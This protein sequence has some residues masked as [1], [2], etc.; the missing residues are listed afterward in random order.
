MPL[1]KINLSLIEGKLTSLS[2]TPYF[3]QELK[4]HARQLQ[5]IAV[6]IT[7]QKIDY[8]GDWL[9]SAIR[10]LDGS[11]TKVLPY[12][13]VFCLEAAL[14]NWTNES[15]LI[16]TAV[17]HEKDFFFQGIDESFYTLAEVLCGE[18]FKHR[19]IQI[20][21]PDLYRHKPLYNS[22]LYH[23]LGH[24]IDVHKSIT[25]YLIL[26]NPKV[27]IPDL[28]VKPPAMSDLYYEKVRRAHLMEYFAD[29]FAACYIG[30]AIKNFLAAFAP[31]NLSSGSHPSTKNRVEN[32]EA[33][34]AG[35]KSPLIDAFSSALSALK[36]PSLAKKYKE[37]DLSPALDN[38]R[39][40]TLS[41]IEEVHGIFDSGWNYLHEALKKTRKPWS[42]LEENKIEKVI[43]DLIEKSI[44]NFMVRE[45]WK[46]GTS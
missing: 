33:L 11:T 1:T 34:L 13:V 21:L 10:Y 32:I 12:E 26:N 3:S 23:E 8:M 31:N 45:L 36:L 5:R 40:F 42:Q 30:P 28:D 19:L 16:T 14:K 24:F 29:L 9:W 25:E 46:H 35:K 39:P 17:L 20:A 41:S 4:N 2:D 22:A 15:Y 18:T 27:S 43:N 7:A 37:I 38:A 44:R 6:N